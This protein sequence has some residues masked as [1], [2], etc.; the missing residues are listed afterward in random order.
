MSLSVRWVGVWLGLLVALGVGLRVHD[1]DKKSLW[2]DELFTLSMAQ[3]HP[4]FPEAGQPLYRRIQVQQIGDGDTFLT[5][6]AAE[7]SPP[8]NDLL[9][10]A[11]VNWLGATEVA[12]R[13]P[14]VL[15]ACALLLWYAGFAWRHPDPYVRRVLGWSLLLLALHPALVLYA[16]EGRAYSVGVSLVGMAGMLWMLRW[17]N[18]L[19]FWQPP[20]WLEIALFAL[21]CYSHYN[22]AL[23]VVLLLSADSVMAT[24]L[25]SRRA[26]GRLLT[27]G[28]VFLVWL[29]LNAHTILFT[30]KGGVGWRPVGARDHVVKTLNDAMA[31]IH[32]FWL[33]L[34]AV[35]LLGLLLVRWRR[36]QLLWPAQGAVRLWVLA[37]LSVLYV[38]LAG[39]VTAK[40][41]MSHPRFFIFI[42][43]IVAV[44]IGLVFAELRQRWL[45]TVAALA[46][47]ALAAPSTRLSGASV[48]EDF[49]GMSLAGV[50]GSDKDT[51]FLYPWVPNR[52]VYR[53]YLERF[54]G[55]DPRSRLVGI[56]A[57]QGATQ[58]CSQLMGH[59]H[60][61]ALGHHS[62][63]GLIDAVYAACG[64]QWPQRST[65]HFQAT[66]AEHWRVR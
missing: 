56:S 14:A 65:E 33:G 58:L 53:V 51:V 26:W 31:V 35:M 19:R 7:Q 13:L 6:K 5:A 22:A 43:P 36:G 39:M 18:G 40:A 1:L 9:E 54:L 11:T 34:A 49:R 28:L 55:E 47:V 62:G 61:V 20:G 38:A 12:A 24:K 45:I 59:T 41:G 50:R 23:L 60:V 57:P 15:A 2:V 25:R 52:N 42:L 64:E 16:K 17:R 46:L 48:S 37:G 63:K 3:Y 4:F 27:M 10:K 44:M 29:V 30:S 32:P 21:A 66:F 8:L